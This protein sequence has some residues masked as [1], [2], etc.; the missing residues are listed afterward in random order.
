MRENSATDATSRGVD[1]S[2]LS[3]SSLAGIELYK[4]QTPIRTEMDWPAASIWSPERLQSDANSK[5]I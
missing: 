3:Q 2:T 4:S 1:L 5:P